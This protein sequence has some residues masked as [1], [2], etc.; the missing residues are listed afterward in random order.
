M[1]PNR[2]GRGPKNDFRIEHATVSAH[3][4]DIVLGDGHV[5]VRDRDSTNGTF[6]DGKAVTEASLFAGQTLRLGDVD[7]LVESTEVSIAIPQFD[8]PMP[9]PPVVLSDGSLLCPRHKRCAGHSPMH[10]LPGGA[11]RC[12]RASSTSERRHPPEALPTLQP[13]L[14]TPWRREEKEEIAPRL[15]PT[16]RQTALRPRVKARRAEA[17]R[18]L[19]SNQVERCSTHE[20]P[21]FFKFFPFLT[22]RVRHPAP[23]ILAD[24]RAGR[25]GT[26]CAPTRPCR[27]ACDPGIR[28]ICRLARRR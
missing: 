28:T 5:T 27:R 21:R 18:V 24:C 20:H 25:S 23:V 16:N 9:A 14:R 13:S 22:P 8:R 19:T 4:C 26:R 10:A 1:G 11:L 3:H 6:V 7:F 2:F 12:V 17:R 15:P